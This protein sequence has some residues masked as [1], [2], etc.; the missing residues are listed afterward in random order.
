MYYLHYTLVITVVQGWLALAQDP[1]LSQT[2]AEAFSPVRV[3]P[4][5]NN[6]VQSLCIGEQCKEIKTSKILKYYGR[7]F[8]TQE[9]INGKLRDWDKLHR[10][11]YAKSFISAVCRLQS[12]KS[13]KICRKLRRKSDSDMCCPTIRYFHK[14]STLVNTNNELKVLVQLTNIDKYQFIPHGQCIS[15]GAC[16]GQFG[17]CETEIIT[18]PLLVVDFQS[19]LYCTFD[20]FDIP[21]YCSCKSI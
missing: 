15:T 17:R 20:M 6:P 12:F 9:E 13:I 3:R 14:N 10:Q 19:S 21:A 2:F 7:L 11:K 1:V 16:S 4:S 5:L 18:I 8:N